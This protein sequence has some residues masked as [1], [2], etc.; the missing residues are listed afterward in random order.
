MTIFKGFTCSLPYQ[1]SYAM[2]SE[3]T[4]IVLNT[5]ALKEGHYENSLPNGQPG[6]NQPGK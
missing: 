3:P 5:Q 2:K 4:A 1:I 6:V